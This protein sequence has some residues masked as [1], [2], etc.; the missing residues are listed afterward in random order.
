MIKAVLFDVYGT[1]VDWRTG[2]IEH[3]QPIYAA[4]GIDPALAAQTADDWRMLYDP[5]MARVRDGERPY[6]SLDVI[7]RE[8]LDRVLNGLD[9]SDQLDAQ[10][11]AEMNKAWEKLPPWPD[12]F[13]ALAQIKEHLP[14]AACSNGSHAMMETLATYA[15]LPWTMICGSDVGRNFKPHRDVYLKSCTALGANPEETLMLACHPD[16]LDAAAALGLQTAYFPRPTEWGDAPF[17]PDP[18]P[19]RFDFYADSFAELASKIV[20]MV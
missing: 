4:R 12:T 3:V 1:C 14:I 15:A 20:R 5:S 7:Q 9:V 19:H 17:T 16:D 11:R 13:S 6:V 10:D 8:N 2:V 18:E